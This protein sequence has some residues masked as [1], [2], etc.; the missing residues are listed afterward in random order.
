VTLAEATF[1]VLDQEDRHGAFRVVVIGAGLAGMALSIGLRQHHDVTVLE[2]A[3]QGPGRGFGFVLMPNGIDALTALVPDLP[4]TTIGCALT[5]ARLLTTDGVTLADQPLDGVIAIDR[6]KLLAALSVYAPP[7]RHGTAVTEIHPSEVGSGHVTTTHGQQIT[8]DLIVACDGVGSCARR[9]VVPDATTA[10]GRVKEIVSVASAPGLGTH[11]A[12]TFTKVLHP[13]GG[14]AI[15]MAPVG[16]DDVVWF[17]Q[18]DH[19]RFPAPTPAEFEPFID[20]HLGDFEAHLRPLRASTPPGRA[21]VWHTVDVDPL[22]MTARDNVI[23][24][25][26]AAQPVLP[27]TS[28]GANGALEDALR[29]SQL[30]RSGDHSQLR[31]LINAHADSRRDAFRRRVDSGRAHAQA[32]LQPPHKALSLPLDHS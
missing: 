2:R 32:F 20:R 18:F 21:H 10:P 31:T 30:L 19:R 13:S 12:R 24:L 23:L 11:M 7:V 15:G 9:L 3:P 6:P 1:N 16:P 14:L 28:Q 22:P 5:R 8:A 17:V 4:L 29:L 26:D 25:G 27:F